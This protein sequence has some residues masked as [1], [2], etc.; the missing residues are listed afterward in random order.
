VCMVC[1]GTEHTVMC[2]SLM[3]VWQPTLCPLDAAFTLQSP[4]PY[5]SFPKRGCADLYCGPLYCFHI[6]CCFIINVEILLCSSSNFILPVGSPGSHV[7]INAW[8]PRTN[9]NPWASDLR[10]NWQWHEEGCEQLFGCSGVTIVSMFRGW[11]KSSKPA[12]T[13]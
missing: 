12:W 8:F 6:T 5:F 9:M 10:T 3:S 13:T 7:H 4:C 1:G 2:A 11:G